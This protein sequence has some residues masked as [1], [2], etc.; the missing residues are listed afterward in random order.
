MDITINDIFPIKAPD[1]LGTRDCNLSCKY[2]F[3]PKKLRN[4][5]MD[6][7]LLMKY[8][9]YNPARSCFLFGGEP[10][11]ILDLYIDFI[12]KVKKSPLPGEFKEQIIKKSKNIITNGTLIKANIDKIKKYGFHMQI[13][14]DGPKHVHD[15]YRVFPNG[16]GTYDAVM[17]GIETCIENDISWSIHGV[18]AKK[19]IKY[20]Y[21]IFTTFIGLYL[22]H[23]TKENAIDHMRHNN[24]Q[25]IFE[26]EYDDEDIDT[27]LEQYHKIADWIYT[28]D[29]FTDDEKNT[30]FEN[31]FEKH[32]GVCSSGASLMALDTN[33]DFYPCHRLAAR[34][35][36]KK[37][38]IGN[39]FKPFDIKNKEMLNSFIE[40]SRRRY[41]LYS[42]VT[43]IY[44]F[45]NDKETRL[46]MWCPATNMEESGNPYFQPA[47]YNVMFSEV[48]RFIPL[49]KETYYIKK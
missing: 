31:F 48:N 13:S 28:R 21:D 5:K 8:M 20:I 10:L 43:N 41:Y 11:L 44:G 37:Y 25:V 3:E 35:N 30:L 26:D 39:V 6:T 42:S 45:K 14:F 32:G 17:K 9:D 34:D 27:I 49:L 18:V 29:Y 2:C 38:R 4:N 19:T 16:S 7:N 47:K 12:E 15:Q 24:F 23:K 40:I 46:F 22:K 33:F 36:N 1:I